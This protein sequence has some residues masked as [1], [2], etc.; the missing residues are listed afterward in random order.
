M[1]Q[2][3][4][5]QN[6]SQ[7][8]ATSSWNQYNQAQS[9][10]VTPTQAPILKKPARRTE[11]PPQFEEAPR[12][13][14]VQPET[15]LA[16]DD[17][18][19]Q[20][21]SNDVRSSLTAGHARGFQPAMVEAQIMGVE[22]VDLVYSNDGV[23][24]KG[25]PL[26]PE[27]LALINARLDE[28]NKHWSKPNTDINVIPATRRLQMDTAP[29]ETVVTPMSIRPLYFPKVGT[30]G[31]VPGQ[32]TG[33]SRVI[34]THADVGFMEQVLKFS[35]YAVSNTKTF[36][37]LSVTQVKEEIEKRQEAEAKLQAV[38]K[39]PK[40][41]KPRRKPL[42]FDDDTEAAKE[43]ERVELDDALEPE[44]L[45]IQALEEAVDTSHTDAM[46]GIATALVSLIVARR[47][48]ILRPDLDPEQRRELLTRPIT[49]TFYLF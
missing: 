47:R 42:Q 10:H 9:P 34:M 39:K 19:P 14:E 7:Q 37:K 5:L 27:M 45:I 13:G 18:K 49:N 29:Y 15:S 23:P 41:K 21:T 28:L 25:L 3:N 32:F 33:A 40:H 38:K 4:F 31:V 1:P 12:V 26:D 48:A 36:S 6:P 30:E 17:L 20:P 43:A 46:A 22:T 16:E 2:M 11:P 24:D 44:D 8:P 35:A